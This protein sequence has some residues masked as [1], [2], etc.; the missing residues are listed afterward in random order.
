MSVKCDGTQKKEVACSGV[1]L[2]IAMCVDTHGRWYAFSVRCQPTLEKMETVDCGVRLVSTG[3]INSVG[4]DVTRFVI[5]CAMS[6]MTSYEEIKSIEDAIISAMTEVSDAIQGGTW[7]STQGVRCHTTPDQVIFV[8]GA[9]VNCVNIEGCADCVLQCL[10]LLAVLS[11]E[12]RKDDGELYHSLGDTTCQMSEWIHY[13]APRRSKSVNVFDS[14]LSLQ[15]GVR[16]TTGID[17]FVLCGLIGC[18]SHV[19]GDIC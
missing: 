18:V 13:G 9:E 5:Q 16:C 7:L 8:D 1:R 15:L 6:Q 2:K 19:S 11:R 12:M 17:E 3:T 10:G 14:Q 4:R